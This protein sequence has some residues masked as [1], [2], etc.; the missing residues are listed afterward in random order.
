V[1]T[2]QRRGLR[3][4]AL[5]VVLFCA[6]CNRSGDTNYTA[7]RSYPHDVTA[8]TEGL[9][10]EDGVLFEST[11]LY[12][13]S[14]LRREDLATGRVIAAVSLPANRFGEGLALLHGRLYQLTWKS[15]TGY[16]Y[17]ARNLARLDSFRF[18][19]EGWGLT[20][21][22]QSLIMSNGSADLRY[23]DPATFA[24]R[25]IVT[26]KD[27]GLTVNALNELEYVRGDLFANVYQTHFI[28]RIDPA[29]GEVLQWIDLTALVPSGD[30]GSAMNVL[31]GIAFD[32]ATGDLLV[33]GKLWPRI[34][35]I[36]VGPVRG[37]SGSK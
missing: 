20:T 5:A 26:V 35:E 9:L 6:A 32:T 2:R 29:T 21:D 1:T 28:V 30:M 33:T 27:S 18:T 23:L 37:Q 14:Q 34:Y 25:R 31:N 4:V 7:V 24:T 12:G 17:D 8:F 13:R 16:L 19:G 36:R 22:G 15:G 10:Y 3:G 11:G